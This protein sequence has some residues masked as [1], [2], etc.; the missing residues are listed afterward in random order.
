MDVPAG[1]VD[2]PAGLV[3]VPYS[4]KWKRMKKNRM[5]WICIFTF[6]LFK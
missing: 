5:E 6:I 3:D 4:M 2:V 1:L